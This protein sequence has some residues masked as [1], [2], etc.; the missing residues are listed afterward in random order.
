MSQC[1]IGGKFDKR[2]CLWYLKYKETS[3]WMKWKNSNMA[4][5]NWGT[6]TTGKI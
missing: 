5:E 1:K 4:E 2:I 3:L 6:G